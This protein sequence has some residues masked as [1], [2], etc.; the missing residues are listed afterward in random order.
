MCF[1]IGG[2]PL[3]TAAGDLVILNGQVVHWSNQ[4]ESDIARHALMVHV[5]DGACH[6]SSE[7]WL[8]YPEGKEFP[9]FSQ[10]DVVRE[11]NTRDLV[12]RL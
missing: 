11:E 4:N 12:S 7:N 1:A 8:Q 6:Y 3:P 9:G 10:E 2:V 5:V